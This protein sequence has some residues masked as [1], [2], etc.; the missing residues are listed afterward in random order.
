RQ[1]LLDFFLRCVESLLRHPRELHALFEERERFFE[2]EISA[3]E[4]LNDFGEAL[5][6]GL[7]R[8]GCERRRRRAHGC[9]FGLRHGSF[10]GSYAGR[11]GAST[12]RA[13]PGGT[14]GTIA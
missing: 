12:R 6:R 5:D 2:R 8:G 4:R 11:R 10:G 9:F 14:P 7:E 13:S 1:E 3:F